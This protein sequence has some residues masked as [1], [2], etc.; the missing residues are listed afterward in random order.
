MYMFLE[1]GREELDGLRGFVEEKK[2]RAVVGS[3]VGL[4]DL[5]GVRGACGRVYEGRGG[6]GKCVLEVV[7]E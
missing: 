5:E 1:S 4:R 7:K 3:V 2:L 6:V